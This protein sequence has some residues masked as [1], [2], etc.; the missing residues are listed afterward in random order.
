MTQLWMSG[1]FD[2]RRFLRGGLV[3]ASGLASAA[4]IGCS[5]DDDDDD[6]DESTA[7]APSGT[8]TAAPDD[9][10]ASD[11]EPVQGGTLVR[12]EP[13]SSISAD[14]HQGHG[15]MGGFVFQ[16]YAV[17]DRLVGQDS[18]TGELTMDLAESIE[19]SPD[20][21]ELTLHV[22]QGVNWHDKPPVNGAPVTAED[23]A[24]NMERQTGAFDPDNRARYLRASLFTTM[25][26]AEAVDESTVR[27][28]MNQP[29]AGFLLGLADK[30]TF[31][32]PK[33]AVDEYGD[34]S[35]PEAFIGSGPFQYDSG[36]EGQE[37][38]LKRNEQY[39]RGAPHLEFLETI[40]IADPASQL[41][42]LISNQV[43]ALPLRTK[44][45]FDTVQQ[46]RSD[47]QI[48]PGSPLATLGVRFNQTRESWADPRA[49]QAVLMLI[50]N[51]VVME[52]SYPPVGWEPCGVLP[53]ARFGAISSD[54]IASRPGFRSPTEED[55][56]EAVK[57]ADAAGFPMGDGMPVAL[58]HNS[59]SPWASGAGDPPRRP[60][61]S[62]PARC[63]GH[64]GGH[65]HRNARPAPHEPGFRAARIADLVGPGL[66]YGAHAE[67]QHRR[68]S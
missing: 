8:S 55:I 29:N 19:T 66:D 45:A 31:I 60:G 25:D 23:V 47:I 2:R 5:D 6:D 36:T 44:T 56:Q 26:R 17:A 22:R 14:P 27:V 15:N 65:G 35:Q 24:F 18:H 40:A 61:A 49:R 37:L 53:P 59:A 39:W 10:T 16:W 57:L 33:A 28:V 9:S 38:K 46:A 7:T 63:R 43:H 62:Q 48:I 3:V 4:L 20:G 50:D 54:E 52:T 51:A 68:L 34:F 42:A 67:L 21:L 11:G 30:R 64:A 58:L 13:A 1:S 41:S 32:V 12:A